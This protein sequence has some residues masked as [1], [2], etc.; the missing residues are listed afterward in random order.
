MNDAECY[1]KRAYAAYTTHSF[2]DNPDDQ[3][4]RCFTTSIPESS[5]QDVHLSYHPS[6]HPA[7]VIM[8]FA[9]FCKAHPAQAEA[10]TRGGEQSWGIRQIYAFADAFAQRSLV[11]Y[12][13]PGAVIEKAIELDTLLASLATDAA[14]ETYKIM[15]GAYA[16][17]KFTNNRNLFVPTSV[18]TTVWH[19]EPYAHLYVLETEQTHPQTLHSA[20]LFVCEEYATIN[21]HAVFRAGF[22]TK[23]WIDMRMQGRGAHFTLRSIGLALHEQQLSIITEQ[24]H[25]APHTLADVSLATV[26][27]HDAR[28]SY[29]GRIHIAPTAAHSESKQRNPVLLLADTARATS[30]PSLEALVDQIHCVHATALGT[31]DVQQMQYLQSRGLS[32]EQAKRILVQGFLQ[33]AVPHVLCKPLL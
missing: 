28:S 10:L 27:D 17:V 9:D 3:A 4:L 16:R 21:M 29:H 22:L 7:I 15:I 5:Q 32:Y 2:S 24:H 11:I 8:P 19:I 12:V 30:V 1:C 20:H 33:T 13:L 31:L 25:T 26:V 18:I 6:P 14:Y 23:H